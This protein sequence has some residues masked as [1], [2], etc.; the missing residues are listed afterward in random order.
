MRTLTKRIALVALMAGA[1]V[2]AETYKFQLGAPA[3]VGSTQLKPGHYVLDVNGNNAV[4][5]TKSGK[6]IDAKTMV[7]KTDMTRV[8]M[9]G[10]AGDNGASVLK[11]VTPAKS[12]IKVVFE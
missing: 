4:L 2:S 9:V 10:I 11:D 6:A 1:V 12:G 5:K 8:T 7:E 3:T